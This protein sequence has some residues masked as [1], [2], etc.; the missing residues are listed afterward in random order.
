MKRPSLWRSRR[1]PRK[2]PT[3]NLE[4]T[5]KW[6]PIVE[7]SC[8]IA[9]RAPNLNVL[10]SSLLERCNSH[11]GEKGNNICTFIP[12][13]LP[14]YLKMYPPYDLTLQKTG[15]DVDKTNP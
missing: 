4:A 10:E 6:R 5:P 2:V 7:G 1:A 9:D 11:Q 15:P 13:Y 3:Q 14:L 12:I 8:G